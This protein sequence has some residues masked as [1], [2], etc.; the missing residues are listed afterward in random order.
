MDTITRL[1]QEVSYEGN[2]GIMELVKFFDKASPQEIQAFKQAADSH[3]DKKAW[4]IVQKSLGV[5]L[6]G[7]QFNESF[8]KGPHGQVK[9][10]GAEIKFDYRGQKVGSK[11]YWA[12]LVKGEWPKDNDLIALADGTDPKSP[13]HFGGKVT[14]LEGGR[15]VVEVWTD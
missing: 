14:K 10:N 6:Q 7:K 8:Q 12:S 1:L 5:K 11:K 4:Q 3:Q 9:Y 2:V 15:K 13:R